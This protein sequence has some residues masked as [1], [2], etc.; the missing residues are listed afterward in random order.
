[1]TFTEKAMSVFRSKGFTED[2][3]QEAKEAIN[4]DWNDP[5]MKQLWIDWIDN[6]YER[7][8]RKGV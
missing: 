8:N 5:Y 4:A 6:E 7:L 2:D 1:M 3:V